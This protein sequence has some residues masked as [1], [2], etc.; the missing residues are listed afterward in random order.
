MRN[1]F[2]LIISIFLFIFIFGSVSVSAQSISLNIGTSSN[3][4]Y[5]IGNTYNMYNT[6]NTYNTTNNI[7][8][9]VNIN[10]GS[11]NVSSLIPLDGQ[12]T[13]N[14]Y[15]ANIVYYCN[16]TIKQAIMI[17]S[18]VQ[19][20][21]MGLTYNFSKAIDKA[22]QLYL[23][24]TTYLTYDMNRYYN[25]IN[26]VNL[27]TMKAG[28]QYAFDNK[29]GVCFEFATLFAAMAHAAG[30]KVR[31]I[32]GESHIW[33]QILDTTSNRWVYVD[34]TWKLFDFDVNKYHKNYIIHAEY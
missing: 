20:M 4:T 10:E 9:D 6:S 26:R 8:G 2:K 32:Y 25:I 17:N 31:L 19:Y 30:V 34:C 24:L 16:I 23:F 1:K 14:G 5:N 13:S 33:D 27:C 22:K 29:S 3:D 12:N 18:N 28:A 7:S 21:A 11:S 15:Y